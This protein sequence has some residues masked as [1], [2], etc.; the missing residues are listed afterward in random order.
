M[1]TRELLER[2]DGPDISKARHE[3][4]MQMH[5]QKLRRDRAHRDRLAQCI[6]DAVR[7]EDWAA[8]TDLAVI[9]DRIGRGA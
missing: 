1:N 5:A 9:A 6:R 8:V 4:R 7:R 2:L 3:K